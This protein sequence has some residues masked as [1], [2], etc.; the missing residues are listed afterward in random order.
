MVGQCEGLPRLLRFM[1]EIGSRFA[2]TLQPFEAPRADGGLNW[3]QRTAHRGEA[4]A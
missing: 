3:W 1:A 2:V 4:A